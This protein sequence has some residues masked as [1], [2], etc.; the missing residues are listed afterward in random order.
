MIMFGHRYIVYFVEVFELILKKRADH[1]V[2]VEVVEKFFEGGAAHS[3]KVNDPSGA[4]LEVFVTEHGPHDVTPYTKKN[5]Y[6]CN[7]RL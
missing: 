7:L 4:L 5:F 3:G 1:L 6:T 2:S